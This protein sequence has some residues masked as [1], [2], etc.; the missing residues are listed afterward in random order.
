M[1]D[2]ELYRATV[3]DYNQ[4]AELWE[5]SVRATHHFLSEEDILFFK[6]AVLRVYL[7]TAKQ[8]FYIK[9]EADCIIAFLGI[10]DKNIDML[11]IHPSERGKGYG[12]SL[13][14]F[15]VHKYHIETVD[16]NEQNEQA[17]GFYKK[18]GFKVVSRDEFDSAGKPYP[19][20]HMRLPLRKWIQ[21]WK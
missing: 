8:L 11:F 13:V 9:N 15:A 12:K 20:L 1:N 18:L 21:L 17:V 16:V 14:S 10:E 3:F 2:I 5:A 6:D 19:I 7:P 4:I